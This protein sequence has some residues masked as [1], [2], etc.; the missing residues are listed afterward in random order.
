MV[1][2]DIVAGLRNALERG[3]SLQIAKQSFISAG[4]SEMEVEDAARYVSTGVLSSTQDRMSSLAN[5]TQSRQQSEESNLQGALIQQTTGQQPQQLQEQGSS[6]QVQP[7]Q[8]SYPTQQLEQN[9]SASNPIVKP[10]RQINW[11]LV[12]LISVLAILVIILILTLVFRGQIVNL[13]S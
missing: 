7:V 8:E 3:Y 1:R 13:F 12:L 9:L 11:K 10:K 5:R 2:E 4:Y 6:Q